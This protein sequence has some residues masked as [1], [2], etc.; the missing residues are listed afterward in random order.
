MTKKKHNNKNSKTFNKKSLT[1]SV[2]GLFKNNPTKNYNYK[3]LATLLNI[4]DDSTRQLIN[5][6]LNELAVAKL[7]KELQRGKY[8]FNTKTGHIRGVVEQTT[9]G[10][11]MVITDQLSGSIFIS[12]ANLNH[13]LNGDIVKVYLYAQRKNHQLEGE[14][15]EVLERAKSTIVG[16]I[17]VSNSFAFVVPDSRKVPYDIFVPIAGLNGAKDSQKVCAKIT[18]WPQKAKNPIGE[19][20]D[21]FGYAGEHNAEMH[22]ILAE[23]ELPYKFEQAVIDEANKIKDKI[24]QTDEAKRRDFR[25]T[26]TFTIDPHDAK[27]FDDALSVSKLKNGNYEIGIHI[28]DV[29]HYVR[30][31]TELDKEAYNRGTSVYLVDRVVSMLP[32][33]LSNQI[34]SLRPNEDKLCF[35]AVFEMDKDANVLNQ[36]FGRTIINSDKRFT[37]E[38]AQ[39]IIETEQGKLS[40]EVL[41]LNELAKKLRDIRFKK[42]ALGFERIEVKFNLDETGK[43]LSVYFKEPKES[44]QLIEEFML[45][46]NKKVAEFIGK[47]NKGNRTFVYRIH[48]R[49]DTEKL[50]SFSNFIK[51]FGYSINMVSNKQ[52]SSSLN[53]LLEE[54]KGSNEQNMI[55]N[56]AIR[57]MAK[58]IYTTN[59]IG[60][61]GLGF[62]HYTHF[63]SPIRRYPDMMVH[64]LLAAYLQEEAPKIECDYDKMCK[65]TSNM[66]K[67]AADAERTS[68]KYK[69]VEFMKDKIGEEFEGIISGVA[70]W[71]LYVEIIENKCEGLIPIRDMGDDYYVFDEDNYCITG[72]KTKQV[73]QLGDKVTI[74]IH[75]ANLVKKQLDFKL[76]E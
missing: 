74:E 15:V 57:A 6:V 9:K 40:T 71:G 33:R 46:A 26:I 62:S 1:N 3:Q 41:L 30:P 22:A 50:S 61:Y 47:A 51:K 24:T 11:A 32:E 66:E 8:R 58:A 4:K 54:I 28:A 18:E 10:Y 69:Q 34:C 17:Q 65:H 73:Y 43:P 35:S 21:I 31:D 56:L 53:S 48:D 23:F 19:I 13:A 25:K 67:K 63:T 52:I 7:I 5:T 44:N 68:I 72:K 45:L 14:V 2:F 42:G 59:N 70:E 37:Y 49:P 60:H 76:I 64:R 20:I 38:E 16:T 36:W 39:K 75:K 27:D 12:Q 55:E 29:T